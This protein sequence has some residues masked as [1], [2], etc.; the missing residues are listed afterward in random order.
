MDG[1]GNNGSGNFIIIDSIDDVVIGSRET[2]SLAVEFAKM[3]VTESTEN[4]AV[5]AELKKKVTSTIVV[6]VKD[7]GN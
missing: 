4:E 6:E 1:Q 3:H 5:I 7:I 2:M